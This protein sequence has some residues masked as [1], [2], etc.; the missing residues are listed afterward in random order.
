MIKLIIKSLINF[1]CIAHVN[2]YLLLY[3]LFKINHKTVSIMISKYPGYYGLILRRNFYQRSLKNCGKNL[4]VFYG[5]FIVY[6]EVEIGDNCTIEEYSIVSLCTLGNDVI[7]AAR[8]SIMS[9]SQHHD[10]A[11]TN[12]VF[13][14]SKSYA[15]RVYIGDNVWIGTHAIIMEDVSSH[16]AVGSGSVVTKNYDPYM[17]IAG[18]PAKPIRDRRINKHGTYLDGND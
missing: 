6:P 11:D 12:T 10:L 1:L 9:G 14:K 5:A 2:Y 13:W 15:K 8:V 7:I 3:F 18:I 17:V 16:S 4:S